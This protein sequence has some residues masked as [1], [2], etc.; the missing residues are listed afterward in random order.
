MSA[1]RRLTFSLTEEQ[2]DVLSEMM[3]GEIENFETDGGIG[4][5][6][7]LAKNI[8]LQFGAGEGA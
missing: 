6:Y 1:P 5:R 3:R 7:E 8:L 4:E 2:A